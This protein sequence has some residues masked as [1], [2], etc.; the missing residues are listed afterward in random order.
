MAFGSAAGAHE[1]CRFGFRAAVR[2]LM[3]QG[4]T[5]LPAHNC[6]V[7]FSLGSFFFFSSWM[8]HLFHMGCDGEPF[9]PKFVSSFSKL[10]LALITMVT[11]ISAPCQGA[12]VNA[13]RLRMGKLFLF[14]LPC[15]NI[16]ADFF[17]PS[18]IFP[19]TVI[20]FHPD[21]PLGTP[22][23]STNTK[24]SRGSLANKPEILTHSL[25]SNKR[26]DSKHINHPSSFIQTTA[27]VARCYCV[28]V[29]KQC[30]LNP[31]NITNPPLPLNI[32]NSILRNDKTSKADLEICSQRIRKH[33]VST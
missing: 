1:S 19:L 4:L 18:L 10:Q 13:N 22:L 2:A 17:L 6:L 8:N 9:L 15:K 33:K 25:S 16:S 11:C 31:K 12:P 24:C 27:Q 32:H 3:A 29:I 21:E 23:G 5:F 7:F 20:S 28:L 30:S 26:I 14:W